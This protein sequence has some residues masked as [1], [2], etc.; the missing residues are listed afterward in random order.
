MSSPPLTPARK[1][2][3]TL[4]NGW[5][6]VTHSVRDAI[7]TLSPRRSPR[8]PIVSGPVGPPLPVSAA[9]DEAT[10]SGVVDHTLT[11][12]LPWKSSL[13]NPDDVTWMN[14]GVVAWYQH[15]GPFL[16]SGDYCM[17]G[18]DLFMNL[19]GNQ[20]F[21]LTGAKLVLAVCF[22]DWKGKM[23]EDGRGGSYSS[24]AT[25]VRF[26]PSLHILKGSAF[27]RGPWRDFN[28]DGAGFVRLFRESRQRFVQPRSGYVTYDQY[29]E[30]WQS[31]EAHTLM[32]NNEHNAIDSVFTVYCMVRS[33]SQRHAFTHGYVYM[34]IRCLCQ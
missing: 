33:L 1:N 5:K 13:D 31:S 4:T 16:G 2:R 20:Y 9:G 12:L 10:G 14:S 21:T 26:F 15:L 17:Q 6:T 30:D 27:F 3:R 32:E 11:A 34:H 8:R 7:H 18:E 25:A 23:T 28:V 24:L 19:R 29:L 22:P